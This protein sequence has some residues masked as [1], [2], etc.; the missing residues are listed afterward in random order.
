MKGKPPLPKSQQEG[1][2]PPRAAV[3]LYAWWGSGPILTA[4]PEAADL[5]ARGATTEFPNGHVYLREP[6][7]DALGL[8]AFLCTC[9]GRLPSRQT[10]RLVWA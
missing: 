4:A 8:P 3:I 2:G 10:R 7:L 9:H 5:S 6:M 1:S